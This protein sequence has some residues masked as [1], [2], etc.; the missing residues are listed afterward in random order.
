M[1]VNPQERIALGRK[2]VVAAPRL[3]ECLAAFHKWLP[4]AASRVRE[5]QIALIVEGDRIVAVD[6]PLGRL[7]VTEEFARRDEQLVALVVF[8]RPAGDLLAQPR[9][10]YAVEL[11][12]DHMAYF[13]PPEPANEFDWN[14][15]EDTWSA[16]NVL[17]LAY[18]LAISCSES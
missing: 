16:R 10:L 4:V 6:T 3:R 5:P 11:R 2:L 7:S 8:Y 12:Q 15:D 9:R 14:H 1:S 17:R 18:E 13:D